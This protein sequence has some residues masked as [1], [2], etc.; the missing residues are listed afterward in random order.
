MKN[1]KKGQKVKN[2][3]G[4][5][6]TVSFQKNGCQVFVKEECNNWYHPTKLIKG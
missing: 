4:Q 3:V 2:L 5:V 1:F 6:L